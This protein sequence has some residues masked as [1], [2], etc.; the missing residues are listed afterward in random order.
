MALSSD[1]ARKVLNRI[2]VTGALL[3]IDN[4]PPYIIPF[5]FPIDN[6]K[7]TINPNYG[8]VSYPGGRHQYPVFQDMSKEV[9]SFTTMY[10][11][12]NRGSNFSEIEN[13]NFFSSDLQQNYEANED[14]S[15]PF[16]GPNPYI[17]RTLQVTGMDYITKI[18]NLYSAVIKPKYGVSYSTQA[19]SGKILKVSQGKSDPAPPLCIFFKNLQEIFIGYVGKADIS[20]LE[21]NID[22]FPQRIKV[23]VEFLPTPDFIFNT[24]RETL[25]QIHI[26]LSAVK[27]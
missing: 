12:S 7:K 11:I 16:K 21:T 23:D 6:Y 4:I 27:L 8:F 9:I 13:T 14:G 2:G 15:S 10:D 17:V 24:Y 1:I 25:E 22:G 19:A 3:A 18:K 5:D 26:A 20:E